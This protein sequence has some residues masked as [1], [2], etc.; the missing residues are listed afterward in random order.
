VLHV[1]IAGVIAALVA[2]FVLTWVLSAVAEGQARENFSFAMSMT[3]TPLVLVLGL[4]VV[5]ISG[6]LFAWIALKQP[7][8]QIEE[9]YRHDVQPFR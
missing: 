2:P 9:D 1:V 6:I 4:P 3:M 7:R 8:A 5:L